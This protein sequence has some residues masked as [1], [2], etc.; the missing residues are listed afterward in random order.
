[1]TR[2]GYRSN[3]GRK[4]SW[5]TSGETKLIRVPEYLADALLKFA[6][7]VDQDV[8]RRGFSTLPDQQIKTVAKFAGK[9]ATGEDIRL[10][11]I[12]W[13]VLYQ[14]GDSGDVRSL[15]FDGNVYSP[16]GE[17][18]YSGTSFVYRD[19][20]QVIMKKPYGKEWG[21]GDP[22][23]FKAS[24]GQKY[25]LVPK[26]WLDSEFPKIEDLVSKKEPAPLLTREQMSLF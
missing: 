19:G 16:A 15:K 12:P 17:H 8:E 7:E 14:M 22:R 5:E 10:T 4:S 25:V 26:T 3:A 2:G 11:P 23:V 9:I 13:Y 1:M 24:K 18:L 20:E 21:A 6:H